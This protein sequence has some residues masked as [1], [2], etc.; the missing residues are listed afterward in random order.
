MRIVKILVGPVQIMLYKVVII[1]TFSLS[2]SAA[3]FPNPID[4]MQVI[5]KYRAVT[6]IENIEGPPDIEGYLGI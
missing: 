3:T 2:V 4:V 5:V 6:Y 1:D